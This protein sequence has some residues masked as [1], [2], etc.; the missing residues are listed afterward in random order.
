[1]EVKDVFEPCHLLNDNIS[2]RAI[3][4][5]LGQVFQEPLGKSAC[6]GKGVTD[7]IA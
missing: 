4:I 6:S 7:H 1:M 3:G 2:R 5:S